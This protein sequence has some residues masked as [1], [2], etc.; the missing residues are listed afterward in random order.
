MAYEIVGADGNFEPFT[1]TIWWPLRS[2]SVCIGAQ[3]CAWVGKNTLKHGILKLTRKELDSVG[4]W[5]KIWTHWSKIWT[6]SQM[7]WSGSLDQF[8]TAIS[9][10]GIPF[11]W[12]H[13]EPW[14]ALTTCTRGCNFS[15][16]VAPEL[17]WICNQLQH[18]ST[19]STL[20]GPILTSTSVNFSRI[21]C[22]FRFFLKGMTAAGGNCCDVAV[23][24]HWGFVTSW[25]PMAM[26]WATEWEF[27]AE[28]RWHGVYFRFH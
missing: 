17:N 5:S 3:T 15:V 10:L 22:I 16:R 26:M 1:R 24:D 27:T 23:E 9:I 28:Q 13:V 25:T 7:D 20:E 6:Q 18:C 21:T 12:D 11:S 4:L 14:C 19:L 2:E 8:G